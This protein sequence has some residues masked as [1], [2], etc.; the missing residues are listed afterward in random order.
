MLHGDT[1][2]QLSMLI[3]ET[4]RQGTNWDW[5]NNATP[6]HQKFWIDSPTPDGVQW[7]TLA[8]HLMSMFLKKYSDEFFVRCNY[9]YHTLSFHIATTKVSSENVPG[10]TLQHTDWQC[11]LR[12]VFEYSPYSIHHYSCSWK[13]WMLRHIHCHQQVYEKDPLTCRQIFDSKW[14]WTKWM[15]GKTADVHHSLLPLPHY[16]PLVPLPWGE[17]THYPVICRCKVQPQQPW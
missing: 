12:K 5:H 14:Q 3:Y 10:K 16:I 13:F 11:W 2:L 9:E 6:F 4:M 17:K 7:E 8:Q 1:I 15:T